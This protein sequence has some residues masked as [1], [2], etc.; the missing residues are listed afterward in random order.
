MQLVLYSQV[1]SLLRAHCVR[2]YSPKT[3]HRLQPTTYTKYCVHV[4]P[5]SPAPLKCRH[6]IA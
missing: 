5:E 1:R 6:Q 3:I 4:I 2:A